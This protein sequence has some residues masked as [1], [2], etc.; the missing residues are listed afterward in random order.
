MANSY[1]IKKASLVD[2]ANKIRN[3][4][5]SE[6]KLTI[7]DI[8]SAIGNEK[9]N[10]DAAIAVL[11]ERGIEVPEGATSADL[12]GLIASV[13]GTSSSDFPEFT[14]SGQYALINDEKENK[15]QNWRIKF[16]TSGK[17]VFTSLGSGDTGIDIFAVGGGGGTDTAYDSYGGGGAGYTKTITKQILQTGIEYDVVIGTGGGRATDGGNSS[18]GSLLTAAGGKK[19]YVIGGTGWFGGNGG[20]GGGSQYAEGGSDGS[21]GNAAGGER[22]AGTGQHTT[23]KEFGEETGDLYATGGNGS[24]W[25]GANA[26]SISAPNSG[27]GASW[28]TTD[29]GQSGIVVIRNHRII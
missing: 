17:L 16:L 15:I 13:D 19:A 3:L 7:A 4:T 21:D 24:G 6:N 10:L 27:N 11:I 2:I 1:L 22:K 9:Q 12:A 5:N 25:S 23:T 26:S 14:Y 8:S 18:F 29:V 28:N 20:S